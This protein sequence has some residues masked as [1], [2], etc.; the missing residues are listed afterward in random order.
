MPK[1]DK[2]IKSLNIFLS[3]IDLFP[4]EILDLYLLEV[5][6][7][8]VT[9]A[10]SVGGLA[11]LPNLR[12]LTLT[13]NKIETL[14]D[15]ICS[16]KKLEGL[17]L[18]KNHLMGLPDRIGELDKLKYLTLYSNRISQVPESFFDLK[19]RKLNLALNPIEGK[20]R[21]LKVFGDIDFI[22]I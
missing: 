11:S 13:V 1:V 12:W 17:Q 3:G 19:L 15:D 2:T 7:F 22:R 14:P 18:A 21:L 4:T 9:R 20:E 6:T 16:L 10:K 5:L 8:G